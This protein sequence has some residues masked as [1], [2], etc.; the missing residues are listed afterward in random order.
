MRLS[1]MEKGGIEDEAA[2]GG[3]NSLGLIDATRVADTM[4]NIRARIMESFNL[5]L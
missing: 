4:R 3:L 5:F 2:A 1:V